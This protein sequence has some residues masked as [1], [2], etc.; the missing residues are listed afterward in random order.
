MLL[1]VA[2][3]SANGETGSTRTY[4]RIAWYWAFF[5]VASTLFFFASVQLVQAFSVLSG[6]TL[7]RLRHTYFRVLRAGGTH[8]IQFFG[9]L[10]WGVLSGDFSRVARYKPLQFLGRPKLRGFCLPPRAPTSR[11][12][13]SLHATKP[14]QEQGNASAK[15]KSGRSTEL[16]FIQSQHTYVCMH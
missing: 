7:G 13:T 2:G 6:S 15:K 11:H 8:R 5:F 1:R 10:E 3:L 4:F 16:S 9:W 12:F 14:S